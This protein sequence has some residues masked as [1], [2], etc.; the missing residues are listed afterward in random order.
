MNKAT[1]IQ[2][3][4]LQSS[5][6]QIMQIPTRQFGPNDVENSDGVIFPALPKPWRKLSPNQIKFYRQSSPDDY[7]SS[8]VPPFQPKRCIIEIKCR[9]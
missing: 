2:A 4:P 6:P 3:K 7:F 5:T 1:A 9:N 8:M